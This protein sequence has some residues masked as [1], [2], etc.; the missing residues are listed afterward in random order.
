LVASHLVA[1]ASDDELLEVHADL[2]ASTDR[3]RVH[4]VVAGAD[5]HPM[6]P[7]EPLGLAPRRV[8]QH[9][10]KRHHGGPVL[11]DAVRGPTP[12]RRVNTAVGSP[13]PRSELGVEVLRAREPPAR[14]EAGL[15]IPVGPLDQALG[16]G[17]ARLAHDDAHG[18][19]SPE[20]LERRG[21]RR[22][23]VVAAH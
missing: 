19:G 9:R 23:A 20:T 13:Q 7:A 4:R 6:I 1:G 2:D 5:P 14:Q 17:V 3:P 18:E 12:K 15:E 16:L 8:G 10:L 21:E 11:G 22:P